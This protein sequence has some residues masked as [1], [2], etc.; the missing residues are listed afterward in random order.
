MNLKRFLLPFWKCFLLPLVLASVGILVMFGLIALFGQQKV[1][2]SV[3]TFYRVAGE[4]FV[5][6]MGIA[7]VLALLMLLVNS[8]KRILPADTNHNAKRI[9]TFISSLFPI[10]LGGLI[11][12]AWVTGHTYLVYVNVILIVVTQIEEYQ[13]YRKQQE[14][15]NVPAHT[16]T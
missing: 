13:R 4:S 1:D 9:G 10:I 6:L 14:K 7:I 11:C 12:H 2:L 3:E 16:T 15:Q 5:P 8:I